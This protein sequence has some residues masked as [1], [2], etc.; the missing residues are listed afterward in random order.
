META[1]LA[2][3]VYGAALAEQRL[4]QGD[5]LC[6]NVLIDRRP[7][8]CLEDPADIRAAQIKMGGQGVQGQV[9]LDM[10]INI[11][12]NI[13]YLRVVCGSTFLIP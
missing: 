4:G 6:G 10:R 1:C 8:R 3:L 13:I 5:P 12:K 9:V 7:G 2:R 11:R